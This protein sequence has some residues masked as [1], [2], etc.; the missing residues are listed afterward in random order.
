[1]PGVTIRPETKADVAGIR[2]VLRDAFPGGPEAE[3]VDAL[4]RAGDLTVSLVA[5]SEGHIVG[6]AQFSRM[7]APFPALGLGP[8]AVAASDRRRGI[9]SSLIR[10]GLDRARQGGWTAVFCLGDPAFYGRF[11]FSVAQAAGFSSPYAGPYFMVLALGAGLPV[12]AGAVHYP[13]AFAAL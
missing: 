13:P 4:R 2:A 11:G 7:T 5:E 9:A 12:T 8:V 6:C 1:M 10:A 3:L